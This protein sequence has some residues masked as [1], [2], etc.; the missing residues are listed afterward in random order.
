MSGTDR[1]NRDGRETQP[2]P[3]SAGATFL[4]EA[5]ADFRRSHPEAS[6]QEIREERERLIRAGAVVVKGERGKLQH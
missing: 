3:R 2:S 6:D 5:V 4:N 1:G